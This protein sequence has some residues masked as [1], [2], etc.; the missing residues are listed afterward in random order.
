MYKKR[1]NK[2]SKG[3]NAVEQCFDMI[4]DLFVHYKY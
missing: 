2:Y 1:Y 4:S 3:M